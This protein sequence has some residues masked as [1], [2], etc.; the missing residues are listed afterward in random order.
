MSLIKQLSAVKP[1]LDPD[2]CT[3][4]LSGSG[5][6]CITE[7][8]LVPVVATQAFLPSKWHRAQ[9]TLHFTF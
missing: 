1:S 7:D 2:D 6:P 4:S 8:S 9:G 3:A 5:T